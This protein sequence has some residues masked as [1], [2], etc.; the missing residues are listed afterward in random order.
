M[1][2][3]DSALR[4]LALEK[5]KRAI[6]SIGEMKF[7]LSVL[8]EEYKSLS[9]EEAIEIIKIFVSLIENKENAELALLEAKNIFERDHK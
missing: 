8:E 5:G 1:K 6:E 2:S 9:K 7:S 4:I 3:V